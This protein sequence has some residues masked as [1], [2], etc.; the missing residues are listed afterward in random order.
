MKYFLSCLLAPSPVAGIGALILLFSLCFLLV[1]ITKLALI[2]YRLSKNPPPE[3]TDPPPT[4]EKQAKPKAL[5]API[6]YL[7]EKKKIRKK[8]RTQY[9]EPK[10][11][12]FE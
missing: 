9:E 6:Y 7:V 3:K 4:Q 1:H 12:N 2:G 5:P 10:R 11:I 8:P